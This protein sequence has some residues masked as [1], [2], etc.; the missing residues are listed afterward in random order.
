MCDNAQFTQLSDTEEVR[1]KKS[2]TCRIGVV[3]VAVILGAC[4]GGSGSGS[5]SG[6]AMNVAE[7][8]GF[9]RDYSR[10]AETKDSQGRTIRAW[11]SPKL[12][13]ANYNAILLDPLIFYP[14]P[15]PNDQ[16]S[17]ETLQQILAYSNDTLKRSLSQR[18]RMVDRPG[19]GVLRLR[20]G[21]TSVASEGEGL[22]PYQYVPMAFVA[23]MAL[24]TATGTPQRAFIVIEA[25]G[26]DSVTG[27]LLGERVRIGTG[28]RLAQVARQQ[29]MTLDTLKPL[30]D[31][32]A[33]SAFPELS[34]YVKAK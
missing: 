28:E 31:D 17:A 33:G 16:V 30:L 15:R 18:F 19:P 2:F 3:L 21:F 29:V 20:G 4:A 7:N 10:L 27:E 13:P 5:G 1:M 14:E 23:T 22:K 34:Q 11:V 8:S 24:R 6:S 26:T 12:T 9:L 32:L 25:E